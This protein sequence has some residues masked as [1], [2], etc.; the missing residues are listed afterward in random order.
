MTKKLVA[1]LMVIAAVA[2][3]PVET[4]T[5]EDVGARQ[6]ALSG[7]DLKLSVSG[8]NS[9]SQGASY[10][11][12]YTS[13]NLGETYASGVVIDF[14]LP[15]GAVLVASSANRCAVTG[16]SAV[17][18]T[19]GG[20]G[21]RRSISGTADFRMDVAGNATFSGQV[22]HAADVSPLNNFASKSLVVNATGPV[23]APIPSTGAVLH[24][25][26]CSGTA[27]TSYAQCVP[28]SLVAYDLTLQAN[29]DV[30][31]PEGSVM[32]TWAQNSGQTTL[33]ITAGTASA[34]ATAVSTTCFDG[35]WTNSGSAWVSAFRACL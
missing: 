16:P 5:A 7:V 19:L 31:D 17:R 15:S 35:L 28:G 13:T 30:L 9:V 18:C 24:F 10:R 23:A 27:L 11:L 29:G 21:Y 34:A 1:A 25:S 32:G 2:C 26:Q 33:S 8:A 6:D 3:G 22:A 12:S 4:A 20:Q 14:A